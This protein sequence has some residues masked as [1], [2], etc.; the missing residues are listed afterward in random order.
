MN[1]VRNQNPLA[2]CTALRDGNQFPAATAG[3]ALPHRA[4]SEVRFAGR[5]LAGNERHRAWRVARDRLNLGE[6]HTH[7]MAEVAA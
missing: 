5:P 2:V 4:N 1:S 6:A 3:V 7:I